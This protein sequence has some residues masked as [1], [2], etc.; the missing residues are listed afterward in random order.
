MVTKTFAVSIVL[1]FST[2]VYAFVPSM[3]DE[4][5]SKVTLTRTT[6]EYFL[7]NFNLDST[8]YNSIEVHR[9]A[10]V[11]RFGNVREV[12][13]GVITN[14]GT[15]QYVNDTIGR[16]LYNE[17]MIPYF[18]GNSIKYFSKNNFRLMLINVENGSMPVNALYSGQP[19]EFKDTVFVIG[20]DIGVVDS[21]NT[22]AELWGIT[23]IQPMSQ[24][25]KISNLGTIVDYDYIPSGQ[26]FLVIVDGVTDMIKYVKTI[27]KS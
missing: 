16:E 3:M 18:S 23:G 17:V 27:K 21:A 22:S 15:V 8:V 2:C 14:V 13:N 12:S 26:Y 6:T 24:V 10:G 4:E 20:R 9:V 11:P 19:S 5:F 25:P 1:F 7:T